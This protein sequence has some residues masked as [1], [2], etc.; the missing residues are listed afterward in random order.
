MLSR[1]G[2]AESASRA[3]AQVLLSAWARWGEKCLDWLAG[4]FAFAVWDRHERLLSLVRDSTGQRPLHYHSAGGF[5]AFASMPRALQ[6]LDGVPKG[7]DER[8]MAELVADMWLPQG[9]TYYKGI[10]RVPSGHVLTVRTGRLEPRRYWDPPLRTLRL[11]TDDDYAEA[12]REQIDRATAARLRRA[13]GRVASHL[14]C[15]YDSSTVAAT[16]ARL[17]AR[18]GERLLAFTSAPRQG[19]QGPMQRGRIADES[20]LAGTVAALHPNIDH[21]VMRPDGT[22]PLELIDRTH[23]ASQCPMGQPSN[24]VWWSAING[25]AERRGASVLLIGHAGNVTL[26]AG[27]LGL[28]ADLIREG[29]WLTWAREARQTVAK[30]PAR[31]TGVLV[32]SF[33]PWMPRFLASGIDR[34]FLGASPHTHV[35]H[36]LN[37]EWAERIDNGERPG[38]DARRAKDSYRI[39]KELLQRFD[40]G[41]FRKA[42]LVRWGIDERDPMADRRVIEFSLSLPPDQLYRNGVSRPLARRAL[43]DRLPTAI[44]DNRLRG[45]QAAEWHSTLT[46]QALRHEVELVESSPGASAIL[47]LPRLKEMVEQWPEDDQNSLRVVQ[48]YRLGFLVAISAAHFI[49]S[50]EAPEERAAAPPR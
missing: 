9:A 11:P 38:R 14:S 23:A 25:E 19:Y 13:R 42:S 5:F 28:L 6:A 48:E 17:M 18:S 4:D 44:L 50:A 37:P 1:L 32:N 46:R 35:P 20:P 30:G 15:G 24:N 41:Y 49:R 43:A 7:V 16:A 45:Y 12:F 10:S 21:I 22:S 8:R 3:D 26:N 40:P 33:G 29:K 31:L 34:I 47:N 2:E 39:R 27:G 36:L